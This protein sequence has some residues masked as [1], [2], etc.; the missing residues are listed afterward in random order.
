MIKNIIL[1]DFSILTSCFSTVELLLRESL[2]ISK[3]QPSLNA[4]LR[5]VPWTLY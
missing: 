4:N 2:L 1:Y 5:S 3:F